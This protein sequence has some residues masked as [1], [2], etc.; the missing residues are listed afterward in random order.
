MF[1]FLPL[2]LARIQGAA[3]RLTSGLKRAYRIP[4]P[5]ENDMISLLLLTGTTTPTPR[6]L[7]ERAGARPLFGTTLELGRN[8]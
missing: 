2:A 3:L 5:A 6:P 1:S 7:A 8:E 4:D